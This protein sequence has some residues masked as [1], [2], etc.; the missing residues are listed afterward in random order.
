MKRQPKYSGGIKIDRPVGVSDETEEKIVRRWTELFDEAADDIESRGFTI[1]NKPNFSAEPLS[2]E[3]L[4][5]T[6]SDEFAD[7]Y[8]R[9]LAWYQYAIPYMAEIRA[10]ILG[11]DT[12]VKDISRAIKKEL[13]AMVET[14]GKMTKEEIEDAVW[15]DARHKEL[16]RDLLVWKQKKELLASHIDIMDRNMRLISRLVEERRVDDGGSRR[17]SNVQNTM[18]RARMSYERRRR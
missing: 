5:G 8:S 17:E 13:R 4:I 11:F 9:H 18:D 15:D 3:N 12:A 1:P 16:Q 6:S 2:K 14:R 10:R 7:L